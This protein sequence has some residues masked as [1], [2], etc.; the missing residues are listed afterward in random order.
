[1]G[2]F[3]R[4][5]LASP[6]A[7]GALPA[8]VLAAAAGCGGAQAAPRAPSEPEEKE[9]FV[10]PE[11]PDPEPAPAPAAAAAPDDGGAMARQA[12]EVLDALDA[13]YN[14]HDARKLGELFADDGIVVE[15]GQPETERG[16]DTVV[17]QFQAFFDAFADAKCAPTRRWIKDHV[18][19]AE[20][21]WT[22]TMTGDAAGAKASHRRVGQHRIQIAV[23]DDAG[24]IRELRV[25]GDDSGLAAQIAGRPGAPPVP[26][27]QTNPPT[28]HVSTGG[29]EEDRL[30]EWAKGLDEVFSRGEPG[31]ALESMADDGDAWVNFAGQP[32]TRGKKAL[33][34]ELGDWFKAFPDQKWTTSGAWGIDGFAIVEH[35]MSATQKGSLGQLRASNKP[36]RSWHW[37]DVRQPSADEREQHDWAYANLAELLQQ[38]GAAKPGGIHHAAPAPKA[39]DTAAEQ[40]R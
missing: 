24:R 33:A 6:A 30:A 4:R 14:A 21:A 19:V 25:Y 22:A 17:R 35:T 28:V 2:E 20:I 29:P 38:T 32:A 11:P 34:R 23:L 16:R 26:V 9:S 3:G 36:V 39:A 5:A 8:L 1:M 40:T 31:P 13:A 27:L 37:V 18:A 12:L 10:V 7:A 15:F